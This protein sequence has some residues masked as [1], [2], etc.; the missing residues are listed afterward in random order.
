MHTQLWLATIFVNV[1]PEGDFEGVRVQRVVV[2]G[3]NAKASDVMAKTKDYAERVYGH[4]GAV[5]EK[6]YRA[7]TLRGF[8]HELIGIDT[9]DQ[10]E[11]NG[12]PSGSCP[13]RLNVEIAY[14]DYRPGT[15]DTPTRAESVLLPCESMADEAQAAIYEM[16]KEKHS[17]RE[18]LVMVY[19]DGNHS[20]SCDDADGAVRF[21]DSLI[22]EMYPNGEDDDA[23]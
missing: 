19:P 7:K 21:A 3:V 17:G 11:I 23:D 2:S 16:V 12:A 8:A 22:S 18:H 15:Q 1:E 14:D 5:V 9:R 6:L 10:A 4:A 13:V 20:V